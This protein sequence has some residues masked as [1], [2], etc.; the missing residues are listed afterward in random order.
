MA[1]KKTEEQ[2][3][4]YTQS[5]EQLEAIVEKIENGELDIDELAEQVAVASKLIKSCKDKLFT[6][7]EAVEKLLKELDK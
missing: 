2:T 3:V 5:V 6:T 7:N 4:N 1:T